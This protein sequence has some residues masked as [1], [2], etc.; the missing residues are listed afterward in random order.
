MPASRPTGSPSFCHLAS[1]AE[2]SGVAML[3][4]GLAALA[5]C[6]SSSA[7][8]A[9]PRQ[10]MK[11]AKSILMGTSIMLAGLIL[12]TC[13]RPHTRRL[14]SG[15]GGKHGQ[16]DPESR[17]IP[18]CS[19]SGGPSQPPVPGRLGRNPTL[20]FPTSANGSSSNTSRPRCRRAPAIAISNRG[21]ATWRRGTFIRG[22]SARILF[23]E[24]YA[25]PGTRVQVVVQGSN[26]QAD[27]EISGHFVNVL[28]SDGLRPR[29]VW[30]CSA[31]VVRAD[32]P[33]TDVAGLPESD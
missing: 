14:A 27:V 24:F 3:I 31:V 7:K 22:S 28:D 23:D 25:D 32:S 2:P 1:M 8:D 9:A 26:V 20:S 18:L 12:T 6:S 10:A 4:A 11:F 21:E 15:A 5:G 16:P 13:P 29:L 33:R 19:H 17:S 30:C